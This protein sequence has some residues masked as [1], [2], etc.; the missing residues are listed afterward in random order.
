MQSVQNL[1]LATI[2][3]A[4]GAIVDKKGYLILEVFFQG[5]LC[6]KWL[7]WDYSICTVLKLVADICYGQLPPLREGFHVKL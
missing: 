7:G 2:A 1:G 3:L 5:W 6:G 4:A